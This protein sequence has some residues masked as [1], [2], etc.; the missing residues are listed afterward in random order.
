M[1]ENR[2][3]TMWSSAISPKSLASRFLSGTRNLR[4]VRFAPLPAELE[5]LECSATTR[6]GG[7]CKLQALTGSG[8][9]KF[10]GGYSSGP[11]SKKGKARSAR[12]GFKSKRLH[13][14][15]GVLGKSWGFQ[16][17]TVAFI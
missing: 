9:C 3:L 17:Q 13:E 8:R 12:N 16:A 10:H 6:S 1:P 4:D 7:L 11:T 15:H 14:P 5:G 2:V